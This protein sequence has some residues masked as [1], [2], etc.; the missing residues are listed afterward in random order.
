LR[1]FPQFGTIN[2]TW[3]PLGRTW[4]DSLQIKAT[5][6]FSH[7][8]DFTSAFTWQKELMMG[9]EQ[10][11]ASA[12]VNDVFNRPMN[13]YISS[14]SRPF[15]W[16]MALNYTTQ[17]FEGWNRVLSWAV[18]DW[19]I[20]AVLQYSSGMPILVPTAQNQ[21]IT[22]LFRNTYA[23]RVPGEPL[24]AVDINCHSCFDPN[25]DFVLNPKAWEDPPA[26]QF[27]KSAA[28]YGDYR[29]MHRPSEA[30]SLGRIFRIKE[31]VTLSIRADFQNVLNRT[32]PTN[33][34]ST[35]AKATQTRNPATGKPI[36]GFGYVNTGTVASQPRQGIIVA[37]FQF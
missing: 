32:F 35:N 12:A 18:R 13:K 28:Y 15:I 4:Y 29:Q 1:P 23:N 16:V 33:P 26:G 19:T 22:H 8:L 17:R 24:W 20:G 30:M 10:A 25:K 2:Y 9:S 27:G 11:G 21:L 3:A 6:R 31:G 36:S 14:L 37:R 5:K 34:T 7:G